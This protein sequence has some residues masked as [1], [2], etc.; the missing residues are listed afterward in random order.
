MEL[1]RVSKLVRAPVGGPELNSIRDRIY[2]DAF[3]RGTE[4]Q[5]HAR[6]A[7]ASGDD[8]NVFRLRALR[9]LLHVE[10]DLLPLGERAK[11]RR[12]DRRLVAKNV[13]APAVRRDEPETLRLVEPFHGASCHFLYSSFL[14]RRREPH[15]GI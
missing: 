15:S 6:D 2:A 13:L 3:S 7:E 8:A 10:L 4:P 14:R 11:A 1:S 9:P 12:L 5:G